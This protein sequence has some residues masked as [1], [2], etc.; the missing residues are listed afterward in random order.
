[1]KVYIQYFE[2]K[3]DGSIDEAL[4]SDGYSPL[5]GRFNLY[6]M[7]DEAEKPSRNFHNYEMYE[8]RRGDFKNYSV[9]YTKGILR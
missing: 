6:S 4:G 8:I 3:L 5:D 7:I 1:M 2:T 9:I